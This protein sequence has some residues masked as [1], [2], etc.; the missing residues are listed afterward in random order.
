MFFEQ[1]SDTPIVKTCNDGDTWQGPPVSACVI[2][3]KNTLT[4]LVTVSACVIVSQHCVSL[5]H[6]HTWFTLSVAH[7][8]L[9]CLPVSDQLSQESLFRQ[10][11]RFNYTQMDSSAPCTNSQRYIDRI[12]SSNSLED[13]V[14]Y[15][16]EVCVVSESSGKRPTGTLTIANVTIH[17]GY[18]SDYCL[19][20]PVI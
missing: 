6:C 9:S 17:T 19:T 12:V 16:P 14:K 3:S 2:A 5:C 4:H 11:F 7:S 15:L 10:T 20:L 1:G 8:S 13:S 18:V